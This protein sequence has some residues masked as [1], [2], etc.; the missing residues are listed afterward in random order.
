MLFL[1][2]A[3]IMC[4][5]AVALCALLFHILP[6]VCGRDELALL[7]EIRHGITP[8]HSRGTEFAGG[9]LTG[10]LW[11]YHF[12]SVPGIACLGGVTGSNGCISLLVLRY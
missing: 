10:D 9:Y 5:A 6:V 2:R 7:V 4:T 8:R 3:S 11:P 12:C 1:L